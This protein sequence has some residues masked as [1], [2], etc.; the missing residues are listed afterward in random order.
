M[1][2]G[3]AAAGGVPAVTCPT[4][5][6]P[7]G[8]L[9]LYIAGVTAIATRET[10]ER[11]VGPV[12]WLPAAALAAGCLGVAYFR[13]P[14]PIRQLTLGVGEVVMAAIPLLA[15]VGAVVLSQRLGGVCKPQRV[16]QT[17][18][19]FVRWLLVVQAAMAATAGGAGLW[20]AAGLLA[21]WPVSGLLARRFPSS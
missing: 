7:A 5:L 10:A 11:R 16:G 19:E 6:I 14:L 21:A 12:R 9:T 1:L 2:L 15:F 17:V 13:F 3:A 8:L 20:A 4:V 18:G